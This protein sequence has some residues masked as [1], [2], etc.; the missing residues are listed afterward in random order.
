MLCLTGC[1]ST[2]KSEKE[3]AAFSSSVS[4]FT[5]YMKEA[6]TKINALDAT[7]K[8]A[9]SE[10][11]DILDEM[12][13]EFTKL[14]E[15][16]IPSQYG[17]VKTLASGASKNMSSAVS[18]YHSAFGSDTFDEDDAELAYEHYSRA[19]LE[20]ECIGYILSGEEI[21]ET[22][23]ENSGIQITIREGSNDESILNKWFSDDEETE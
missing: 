5:D 4:S 19:M 16:D 21:P 1:G 8:E 2:S 3:L 22:L 17:G 12:D 9:Y 18:Y 10:L 6:D 14:S 11:L 15:L 7:D 20:V 23:L 13:D